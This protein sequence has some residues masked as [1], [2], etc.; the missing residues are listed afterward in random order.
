MTQT[1]AILSTLDTKGEE[2]TFVVEELKRL[3]AKA[4]VM[5]IG[6]VGTPGFAGDVTRETI[7]ESGGTSLE[8]LLEKPD[9]EVAAPV[10]VAGATVELSKRVDKGE[11]QGLIGLGG[12]QGTTACTAV[13]RALPYG[14]PKVMVSTIAAGDMAP[15]IG[16]KDITM[17]FSVSDILGLNPFMR[18]ILANAA[19]AAYGM[20]LASENPIVASGEKPLVAMTNLGVLTE[21]ARVA[22]DSFHEAG[23][24]TIVFHAV[25]SGGRA[26]EEMMR[27]GIVG[28][29]FDYALGE[30]SDE[31]FKGLR[32]GGSERL[33]L[34]GQMGIPQVLC[35]G[36]TEH[37][38]I[39]CEPHVVPDE[40][41]S[42]KYVFHSPIILAPRL[43]PEQMCMVAREIAERLQ[44]TKGK[45][46]F[47][48]PRGGTS[49]YSIE[50]G[51]LRDVE[52]DQLFFDELEKHLPKTIEIVDTDM[53]AE[54]SRF[55][56]GAVARLVSMMED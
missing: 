51:P 34:A 8:R 25:G 5:D 55:V 12:T 40:W 53:E 6:V 44:H 33:K 13:M 54:D 1:I 50:G 4:L 14:L 20:S 9:R 24:E 52:G 2:T 46:Y 56:R 21:G 35:P 43:N 11:V 32:A 22:I 19:G 16:V 27:Q 45:A 7:A 30:I 49:R 10:M 36:G 29:V 26:M 48:F 28:A 41:K 15:F 18:R 42:N 17:M 23:Y 3:G 39:L 38:G 31:I 37:L 47:L